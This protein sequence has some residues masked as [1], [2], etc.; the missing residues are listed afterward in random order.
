MLMIVSER[1]P[2]PAPG[3]FCHVSDGLIWCSTVSLLSLIIPAR[4]S[5]AKFFVDGKQSGGPLVWEE[6]VLLNVN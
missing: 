4:N 1:E 3:S 2:G 6:S 5:D